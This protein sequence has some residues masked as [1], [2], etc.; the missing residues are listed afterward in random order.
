MDP[1]NLT[2][3]KY[4][5]KSTPIGHLKETIECLKNIV[6]GSAMEE[7][8]VLQ[9]IS[10]YEEE[11][12]KQINLND[13]KIIISKFSKDSEGMYHDQSKKLKISIAP[14]SENID[15]IID[16]DTEHSHTSLRNKLD[17]KLL[18]YKKLN[19]NSNITATNSNIFYFI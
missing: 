6:G 3:I 1:N 18:E 15:K 14:L 19:Y 13:D 7:P 12:F 16:H 10:S 11:H 8:E 9:E 2:I 5:I 4:I 17:V